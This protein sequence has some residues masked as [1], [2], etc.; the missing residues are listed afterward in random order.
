MKSIAFVLAGT[1]T[2]AKH[3]VVLPDNCPLVG[4][5]VTPGAAQSAAATVQFGKEG[6]THSILT[7]NMNPSGVGD[8]V[9]AAAT[10]S[11]T[12]AEQAQIFGPTQALEIAV[13]L[14]VDASLGITLVY[15]EYLVGSA[16]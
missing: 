15:D 5:Y 3:Y 14:A 13:D 12:A 6:A 9:K 7:A 11:V 16:I 8:V 2:A 10:A 4:A 1:A